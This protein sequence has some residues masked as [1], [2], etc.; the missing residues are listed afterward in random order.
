METMGSES[1][2]E[3]LE[4]T[5]DYLFDRSMPGALMTG[6]EGLDLVTGGFNK[7]ELICIAGRPAMGKT[8]FALSMIEK[9]CIEQGKCCLYF[10]VNSPGTVLLKRLI[11]TVA[12]E[13]RLEY[14]KD[15]MDIPYI[16]QAFE[17]I[18]VAPLYINDMC[19]IDIDRMRDFCMNLNKELPKELPIDLIVVDDYQSLRPG[20]E[21]KDGTGDGYRIC[22]L[23]QI[24]MDFNC[25]VV[26]LSQVTRNPENRKDH[27]PRLSDIRDHGETEIYAD[28]ILF[29]Y[30][31]EY[32][33]ED[34]ERK[35]VADI[36][37]AK[38]HMGSI[39]TVLFGFL[40]WGGFAELRMYDCE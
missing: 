28:K 4:R 12:C 15:V 11:S 21:M 5:K 3:L 30:R 18:K 32:Y 40:P 16:R 9:I 14:R 37:V 7:G 24:A 29:I 19:F 25:P 39:G 26:V 33:Y 35:G 23:K 8:G 27:H 10:S 36:D 2:G 1:A 31:D 17:D 34:T 13:D 22:G 6:F 38:N 20:K